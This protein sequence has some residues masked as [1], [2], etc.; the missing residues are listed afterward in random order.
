MFFFV[1][2]LIIGMVVA[3]DYGVP[4][5]EYRQRAT[6]FFAYNYL[7]ND[8]DALFDYQDRC[9]GTAFELPLVMLEK[10]LD[11]QTTH[12]IFIM[13]HYVVFLCFYFS[14]MAFYFLTRKLFGS[15][16]LSLVAVGLLVV[17]PRI[18]A[19]AF[20]NSKDLVFMSVFIISFYTLTVFMERQTFLSC[21][22]H[23]ASSAFLIDIR[24]VGLMI[25][26]F[27]VF[28]II[29]RCFRDRMMIALL[30]KGLLYLALLTG[31]VILFWPYLWRNPMSNFVDAFITMSHYP[32]MDFM[33]YGGEYIRSDRLPWH[34]LP[35]WILITIPPAYSLFFFVGASV[36]LF[37]FIKSPKGFLLE[38][39]GLF[40][41]MAWFFCPVIL[42]IV[43]K[44]TIY[45]EWR[46]LYFIYPAFVLL[47]A[48]GIKMVWE[49]PGG[50]RHMLK[51]AAFLCLAANM[52]VALHFMVRFH[53]HGNVY[54]NVLAGTD[55]KQV[56]NRFEM[57]Y[58]GL[59]YRQ[60][61]EKILEVD[62]RKKILVFSVNCPGV[63]NSLILPE[64]E[65]RRIWFTNDMDKADYFITNYRLHSKPYELEKEM[66]SVY[67]KGVKIASVF[68]SF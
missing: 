55:Y 35:V 66:F 39:T 52:V 14:C 9:Y 64:K 45:D 32:W 1:S 34:Y 12:T 33:L 3:D 20:Y 11:L 15:W 26:F 38:T 58:W 42:V 57:D 10:V 2:L 65:K 5:D 56:K 16:Q 47:S 68:R 40:L 53:P 25:P 8:D 4:W 21:L 13:R 29:V 28:W 41:V 36:I 67:V 46:Q 24:V 59:A 30:K 61:L 37:S 23:A 27:T 17:S 19:H 49:L 22:F 62:N 60:A 43:L 63:Y 7:V 48:A 31:L 18:F 51:T 54:F 44:S 50:F 6:G